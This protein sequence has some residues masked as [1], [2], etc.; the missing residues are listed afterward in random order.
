MAPRAVVAD[1]HELAAVR[2]GL[3][4]LVEEERIV[5]VGIPRPDPGSVGA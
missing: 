1:E 2:G 3:L 5:R 4:D